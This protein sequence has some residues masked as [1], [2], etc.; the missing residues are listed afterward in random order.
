MDKIGEY[1]NRLIYYIRYKDD[2]V[3]HDKLPTDNW[4][5]LPICDT[6]ENELISKI[7][8]ICIDKNVRYLCAL[9]QECEMIHDIFDQTII[10]RRLDKGLNVDNAED[11]ER[12]P[13]TTWHHD[14]EEGVWFSLTN[15]FDDYIDINQVICLDLTKKG[16]KEKL[17]QTINKIST[18]WLPDD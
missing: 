17:I 4:L 16:V 12:E 9:G 5:V 10:T 15:A 18:G 1:N 2:N 11:F 6:K 3:L 7:S 13:M 8:Y 14:F